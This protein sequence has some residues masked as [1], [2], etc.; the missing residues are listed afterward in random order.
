MTRTAG[1][2]SMFALA[3]PLL[4]QHG[5]GGGVGRVTGP[6]SGAVTGTVAGTVSAPAGKQGNGVANAGNNG[7]RGANGEAGLGSAADA[8]L[9]VSQNAG[10]S[11]QLQPLL[12]AGTTLT[13]SAA[14]FRNEGQFVAALHVAHNLNIPFD[15]LKAKVTGSNRVS[16]GKA[17]E[18]LRPNL[19][20]KAVRDNIK[21]ADHQATRDLEQSG[22]TGKPAPF[23]TRI[24]ANTTLASRLQGLLPQ[25]ATLQSAAAGF[26]NE[27]QF[28]ATLEASKTLNLSFA[29]LKDRVTAGQSL[30][31][32]IH[33]LRPNLT[34]EASD[35]AAAQA[36]E[37][38]KDLRAGASA[39]AA[40]SS[41]R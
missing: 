18:D 36:E 6:V 17:I 28:I 32:A 29:D 9:R 14:G 13:Q 35:N 30:G 23:V 40:E 19:D 38:G 31:Q 41:K 4:A 11:A 27:G 26:K 21:L 15:Q 16:L 3:I 2:S 1:I 24:A 34:E 25:G 20:D 8:S 39:S 5:Q 12:P 10:L 33:S 22:L 37:Q 7:N